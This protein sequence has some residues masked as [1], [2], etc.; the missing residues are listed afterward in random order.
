MK[1]KAREGTPLDRSQIKSSESHTRRSRDLT[2]EREALRSAP[3]DSPRKD[4]QNKLKGV[5][6]KNV[7]D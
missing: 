6:S 5:L 4:V 3:T 7:N 2:K 1:K